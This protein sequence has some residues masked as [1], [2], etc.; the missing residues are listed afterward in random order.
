MRSSQNATSKHSGVWSAFL[1][2]FIA[3]SSPSS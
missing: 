1:H 3:D 2:G